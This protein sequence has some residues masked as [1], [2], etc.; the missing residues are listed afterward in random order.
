[1]RS[2]R[3]QNLDAAGYPARL[4]R[5]EPFRQSGEYAGAPRRLRPACR[6]RSLASARDLGSFPVRFPHADDPGD[7]GW[8]VD[9]S[10]AGEIDDPD[11][12]NDFL[13]WRVN[14]TSRG[15]ALLMLFL[16]SD[17]SER[18]APTRIRVGSHLDIAR[19]LEPAGDAGMSLKRWSTWQPI[20][21]W[22]W[23]SVKPARSICVI[24]SW[25]TPRSRTSV[26]R[27][28]SWHS[29]RCIRPNLSGLNGKT[30]IIRR[31]KWRSGAPCKKTRA[32]KTWTDEDLD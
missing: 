6:K 27:H 16:F 7:T 24:P 20:G 18:D 9:L 2:L 29:R 25:S 26:R 23:P 11:E 10:F 5:Q 3:Q 22:R 30:A 31:S 19:L 15:R 21:R 8:H 14:V 17:V 13:S 4:L 12:R 32:E 28:A 1:M